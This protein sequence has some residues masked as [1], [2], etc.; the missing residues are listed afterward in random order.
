MNFGPS[1]VFFFTLSDP[2]NLYGIREKP[3]LSSKNYLLG[4]QLRHQQSKYHID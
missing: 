1:V 2:I 3:S 4:K